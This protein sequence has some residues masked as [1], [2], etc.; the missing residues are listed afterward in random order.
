M[1]EKIST[2]HK[3]FIALNLAGHHGTVGLCTCLNL[4]G[5]AAKE[6]T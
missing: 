5:Q 6:K 3:K 2:G 4:E 1:V